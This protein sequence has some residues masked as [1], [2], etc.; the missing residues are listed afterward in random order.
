MRGKWNQV[1]AVDRA[2]TK[3]EPGPKKIEEGTWNQALAADRAEWK[4]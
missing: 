1:V 4:Y 3:Y 2:K